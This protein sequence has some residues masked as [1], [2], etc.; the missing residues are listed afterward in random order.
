MLKNTLKVLKKNWG[1]VGPL[2][3]H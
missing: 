1:E 2:E 3:N